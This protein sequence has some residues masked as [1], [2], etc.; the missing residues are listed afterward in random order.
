MT[1][2]DAQATGHDQDFEAENPGIRINIIEG[3]DA[4]NFTQDLY[5]SAFILGESLMTW[6]TWTSSGH[7]FAAAG[8]LLD[9]TTDFKQELAF[10]PKDV[11][12]DVTKAGCT[13]FPF[14]LMW[15][16]LLPAKKLELRA[17]RNV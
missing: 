9:L 10:S 2:P 17:A 14:A 11:G 12:E 3:P 13:E 16:A 15:N 4:T 1:A 7:P 5:T 8:W 6:S